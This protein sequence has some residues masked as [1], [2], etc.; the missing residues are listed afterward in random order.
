M[1]AITSTR[2][3]LRFLV[4]HKW[5]APRLLRAVP[6]AGAPRRY[7]CIK[8]GAQKYSVLLWHRKFADMF[9][10]PPLGLRRHVTSMPPCEGV[11]EALAPTMGT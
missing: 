6:R 3:P 4:N 2:E 9:F 1:S 5:A 10:I 11:N 7:I 8:C